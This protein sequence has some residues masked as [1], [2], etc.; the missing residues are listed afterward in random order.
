MNIFRN[1]DNYIYDN[2]QHRINNDNDFN[3]LVLTYA[4]ETK[5]DSTLNKSANELKSFSPVTSCTMH[6]HG[7]TVK[8]TDTILHTD[9]NFSDYTDDTLDVKTNQL[10]CLNNLINTIFYKSFF[11]DNEDEDLF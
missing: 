11:Y 2:L 9:Q 8:N 5:L 3:Q 6:K 7:Y 4:S 1:P 10:M